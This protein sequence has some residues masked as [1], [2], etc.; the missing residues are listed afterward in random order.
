MKKIFF[1]FLFFLSVNTINGQVAKRG[2]DIKVVYNSP[3][4]NFNNVY[5]GGMGIN[6][7]ILYPF[8]DNLQFSLN[9]GYTKWDFDNAAYNL[10]NTNANYTSFDIKAPLNMIPITFGVKYFATNSKVRPYFSVEFGFFYYTQT[11]TGTYTWIAKPGDPE[12]TFTLAELNDSGFRT[13][14]N[15][16]AGVV[17]PL[18]NIWILDFQIKMNALVNAQ[19]VG[20]THNS[21]SIEGNSATHY[22][23]S[24]AGGI[25]YYFGAE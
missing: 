8:Y 20:G 10:K 11:A 13:M 6:I 19:S 17:A 22:F 12:D 15:A 4:F 5:K 3:V 24:I 9:T 23:L 21:G 1:M 2:I 25:N 18:N 14:V 7:G 16:G